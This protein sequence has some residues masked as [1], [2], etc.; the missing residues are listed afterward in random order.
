[1]WEQYNADLVPGA[2]QQ[3]PDAV[4]VGE[5]RLDWQTGQGKII[6]AILARNPPASRC[7]PWWARSA[8][9]WAATGS[10]P[11]SPLPRMLC[12]AC[13]RPELVRR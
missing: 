1:M 9:T 10:S 6:S 2:E 4:I 5:G 12:H 3:K 8:P 11:A 7:T 13:G